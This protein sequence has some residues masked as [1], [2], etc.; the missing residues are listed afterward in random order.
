MTGLQCLVVACDASVVGR[1]TMS[2]RHEWGR[3]FQDWKER[4]E[5]A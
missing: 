5:N 1:V 4:A 2:G 3:K